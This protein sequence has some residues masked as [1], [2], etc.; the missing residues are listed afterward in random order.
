MWQRTSSP[1]SNW[2]DDKFQFRHPNSC[3][4]NCR[5]KFNRKK[6]CFFSH[7]THARDDDKKNE[8]LKKRLN[9][10]EKEN[11][12]L[13]SS[14]KDLTKQIENKF[15]LFDNKIEILKKTLEA[16]ESEIS[17]L[18]VKRNKIETAFEEKINK[19]EKQVVLKDN[20]FK[21]DKCKFAT[22]S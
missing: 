11:K 7:I 4:Y 16:K 18:E 3:K 17:L 8:D 14:L 21:C 15:A 9:Q 1:A 19:L 10:T 12:A 2:F 6:I 20:K 22:N 5:C 13:I